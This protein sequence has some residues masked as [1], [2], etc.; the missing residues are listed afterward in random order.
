MSTTSNATSGKSGLN[1]NLNDPL[2]VRTSPTQFNQLFPGYG[3]LFMEWL[4]T[5]G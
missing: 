3:E 2:V 4:P 1:L 5:D